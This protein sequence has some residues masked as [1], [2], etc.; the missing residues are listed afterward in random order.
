MKIDLFSI[1][2]FTVHGYGLMIGLGFLIA[3]LVMGYRAKKYELNDDYATTMAILVL[4]FGFMGGKLLFILV[5]FKD[6]LASPLSV[7]GSEGFV[8]YGGIIT[9]ILTIYVYSRIK[10]IDFL[11]YIDLI[12]PSVAINQAFGRVGCFL[13]GCCYGRETDS[14]IGVVFPEGALAPAGVK[15]LPTQLFSAGADMALAVILMIYARKTKYR[16]NVSAL[17][18]LL[19]SIGRPIIEYFRSDARGTVGTLSTSQFISIFM[20]LFSIG[21]FIYNIKT[22]KQNSDN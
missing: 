12:A 18:L 4:I 11:S 8:V 7:L 9:G 17:Y 19:Y 21:F 1:G 22:Q 13:A 15:L 6:F 20:L 14:P 2:S 10:K 5:E 3:Y 16:G